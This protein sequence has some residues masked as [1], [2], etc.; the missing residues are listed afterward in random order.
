[1][2]TPRIRKAVFPVAGMGTRFLPA[3]KAVPKEMLPVVDKPV[4]QYGVEEAREAGI[5][6]FIFV[7]GRGKHV[8]EDHFD[9]FF[10]LEY[11]LEASGKHELL[12]ETR[13]PA[14]MARF[15]MVRQGSPL[16]N[17]HAVLLAKDVVGDEPFA[18]LWGDDV[19]LGSPPFV[20]Q[21]ID[22]HERTGGL[23]PREPGRQLLR[24]QLSESLCGLS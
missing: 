11:R 24:L 19:V 5:E 16:G 14:E 2:S 4:I 20:K 18:M 7:T 3:T 23:R 17:G 1:M 15:V 9:R 8:I 10:E 6:Q 12:E 22:A 21:L 13:R